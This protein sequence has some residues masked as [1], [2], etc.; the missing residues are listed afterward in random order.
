MCENIY[1]DSGT[2]KAQTYLYSPEYLLKFELK[3]DPA[4]G[5]LTYV[6]VSNRNT[7]K[8]VDQLMTLGDQLL[9][10]IIPN[11]DMNIMSGDILKAFGQDG[12]V[13][14]TGIAENQV[15]LPVYNQEVLSQMENSYSLSVTLG[16]L[17]GTSAITQT[18][19]VGTGYLVENNTFKVTQPHY[20]NAVTGT[21]TLKLTPVSE[22]I[23][24]FHTPVVTPEM[25]MVATRLMMGVRSIDI[26]G[27]NATTITGSV[28]LDS[29]GSEFISNME[30]FRFKYFYNSSGSITQVA[31]LYEYYGTDTLVGYDLANTSVNLEFER[32]MHFNRLSTFDWHPILYPYHMNFSPYQLLTS[33]DTTPFG[34]IDNYTIIDNA[35][36]YNMHQ[37]ALLS[38]FS[39]PQMGVLA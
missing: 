31:V 34:D 29:C 17:N 33:G 37:V 18:T 7:A 16:V 36:M 19:D 35:N 23:L 4:V 39:V 20:Q 22:R 21:P 28:V 14:L 26:T 2:S 3:G 6:S 1:L 9:N 27:V 11:E 30:V 5:S 24:N 12:V 8:T 13:R 25:V 38:E 32:L 10:A 15:I